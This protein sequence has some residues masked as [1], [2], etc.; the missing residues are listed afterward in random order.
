[1]S[2]NVRGDVNFP[3]T[4]NTPESVTVNLSNEKFLT[5]YSDGHVDVFSKRTGAL[6]DSFVA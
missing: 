4:L 5:V 3:R 2:K 1:M 6:V